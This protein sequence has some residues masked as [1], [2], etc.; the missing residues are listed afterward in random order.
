MAGLE[1]SVLGWLA[2]ALPLGVV[3]AA[4]LWLRWGGDRAG[5]AGAVAAALAAMLAFGA[6][7]FLLAVA[8]WKAAVLSCYV[9]YIIWSALILYHIVDEA[10]AIHSIGAG[11]AAVTEDH[12]MQL[13]ILGFAFSAF[14]QGVAG[15]GVPVAVVAPLLVGLGFPPVQAAAVPLVGH[16]WSVTMGD[17]ASSFQALLAVTGL[18][19]RPLA[20][21]SACFLGLACVLTGLAVAHLHAGLGAIRRCLG[22]IL[23]LSLT[24][25]GVQLALAVAGYW[26]LAGFGAGMVGLGLS[27][28]GARL[29]AR[30]S[31]SYLGLLPRWPAPAP[32]RTPHLALAAGLGD[33]RMGFHLAF[34]AYYVLVV[35]V[36]VATLVPAIHEGLHAARITV[37]FPQTVTAYGW[38]THHSS[39]SL[40]P[41]A[42][43]GALLLYTAL[44]AWGIYRGTGRLEG[45]QW[46]AV[47]RRTVAQGVPTS[48]AVCFMVTMA[49]IM[50]HSGMTT[51]LAT[52]MIAVAGSAYPIL[53]P[54]IGLLGCFVT[55][56][57]TNS[58]LLFGGLQRDVAVLLRESP[59][60][61]AALQ[62]TGAALGSM[63]APAKILIGCATAGLHGRE[64]EV[65]RLTLRYCLPMTLATGLLGWLLAAR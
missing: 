28:A 19:G 35:V 15:F 14:L 32:R 50:A 54:F 21:W 53:S 7:P 55:G 26:I 27:L 9:L 1:G 52:G 8:T 33:R 13:L 48:L 5:L 24:M 30:L 29:S 23:V 63:V 20:L 2:A 62:T 41:L 44:V 57:N 46:R 56:S 40:F 58:N 43:P 10:G 11:V 42:H 60:V 38:V 6:G 22:A 4:M 49:T 39:R 45:G 61:M 36:G 25:A 31:G 34:S 64:G 16:A 17:L 51:L 18:P 12:V 37:A 59:A 47:A 65:M 3:L